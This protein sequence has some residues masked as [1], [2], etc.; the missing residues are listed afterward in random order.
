VI[1][2]KVNGRLVELPGPTRLLDYVA[3][4]GVDLGERRQRELR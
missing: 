4:L 2:L 1:A 3:G